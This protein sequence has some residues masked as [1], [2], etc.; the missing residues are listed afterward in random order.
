MSL[1]WV[2]HIAGPSFLDGPVFIVKKEAGKV[3]FN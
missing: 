2:N 1:L 3:K